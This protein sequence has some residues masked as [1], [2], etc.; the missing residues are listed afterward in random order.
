M[1]NNVILIVP[2]GAGKTTIAELLGKRLNQP[3]YEIDEVRWDYYTEIGFDN[4]I[5]RQKRT[6]GGLKAFVAYCKPFEAYAVER[7]L[8][9]HPTDCIIPFGGGHSVY[10]DPALFERVTVALEPYPNVILLL[11]S[12][13]LAEASRVLTERL[14]A[15]PDMDEGAFDL[16]EHFIHHPSNAH[17][18][19]ITVYTQGKT[20]D[21]TCAEIIPLLKA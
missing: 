6:E 2:M 5:A 9:D 1:T 10:E 15:E 12:P 4:T 18:A 16:N 7:I 11:P 20:P 8:A 21:E 14:R 19:V 17:L 13:D 3:V